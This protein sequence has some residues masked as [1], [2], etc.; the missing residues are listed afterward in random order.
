[1][2]TIINLW[3]VTWFIFKQVLCVIVLLGMPNLL[4]KIICMISSLF[5]KISG[6]HRSKRERQRYEKNVYDTCEMM[7]GV[8][9]IAK[10]AVN[11]KSRKG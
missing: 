7:S 1:M 4:S 2:E 6:I 8:S 9:D 11:S 10:C 5:E 3:E